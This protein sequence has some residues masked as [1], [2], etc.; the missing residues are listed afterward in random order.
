MQQNRILTFMLAGAVCAALA[1]APTAFAQP[2]MGGHGGM[3][4]HGGM[5]MGMGMHG[6][7]GKHGMKGKGGHRFGPHNAAV[8]FLKMGEMLGLDDGQVVRLQKLRDQWID[9][10]SADKAHLKAAQADLKRLLFADDIVMSKV[11]EQFVIIGQIEGRL[12]RAFAQQLSDIKVMLS[13]K[14]KATLRTHHKGRYG[15]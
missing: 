5:G 9:A 2:G 6:G 4:K 8:H 13:K 3:S 12:W 11:E 1:L 7:M 15:R 10:H 14:Q